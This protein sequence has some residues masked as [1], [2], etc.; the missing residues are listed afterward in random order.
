MRHYGCLLAVA[1]DALLLA[2]LSCSY[3]AASNGMECKD[4]V[5][6]DGDGMIDF[7]DD[8]GCVSADDESEDSSPSPQ[9]KDG[10]DND[11]DGKTDFPND[12]GCFA[13]QQDDEMDDCP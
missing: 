12:P 2:P 3:D 5:D 7:P 10:R 6:N 4:G 11:H 9:C 13:P 8:R 1:I